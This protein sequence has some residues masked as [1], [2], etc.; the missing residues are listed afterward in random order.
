MASPVNRTNISINK[1]DVAAAKSML[2]SVKNGFPRAF[3]RALNRTA[4]GVRTDM[5]NI[6]RE[7]YNFKAAYARKRISIKRATY[8]NLNAAT[9]STGPGTHLTDMLGTRKISTGL[10]VDIK[11]STGR[12]KIKHAFINTGQKSGK[13]IAYR[14][15]LVGGKRVPRYDIEALYAPHPEQVYNTPENWARLKNQASERL[16]KNLDHE[17][18]VILKDLA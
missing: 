14:R 13:L 16:D 17:V 2:N 7:E 11:K 10:S 5:V 12:Q 8:S 4:Q 15:E 18:D 9:R 6:A 1:A 3:S